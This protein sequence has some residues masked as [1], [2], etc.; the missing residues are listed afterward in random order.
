MEIREFCCPHVA[1]SFGLE[2]ALLKAKK[3]ANQQASIRFQSFLAI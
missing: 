2:I 3:P 1:E